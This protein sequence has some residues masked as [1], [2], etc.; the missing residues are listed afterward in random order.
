MSVASRPES[1]GARSSSSPAGAFDLVPTEIRRL[2]EPG[3]EGLR[4]R[5]SDG[6]ESFLSV[7]ML[8]MNCPCATCE[9][10]RGSRSHAQPLSP[11]PTAG[12]LVPGGPA[13][14]PQPSGKG[15]LKVLRS[16]VSEELA[17]KS[18]S[19]VGNY[20]ISLAWGDGHDSGIYSYRLLRTLGEVAESEG[21]AAT[22]PT[23]PR[24]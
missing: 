21:G 20:A 16:T 11:S 13:A 8:R 9:E 4:I 6:V 2:T 17:L 1:E 23:D 24:S 5:W 7:R 3:S 10:R 19:A 22:I 15:L 14:S 18:V 12:P